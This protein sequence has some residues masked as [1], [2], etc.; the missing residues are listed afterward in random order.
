MDNSLLYRYDKKA[1]NFAVDWIEKFCSHA[2]G[3]LGGKPFKLEKWQKEE[4]IKPLFGWKRKSDGLRRYKRCA[5][6][7]PR[8]NGKSTLGSA[9]ALYMLCADGE[10][11]AEIYSAASDRTQAGI[12]HEVAKTMVN[13]N[14]EL[15][16]RVQ[17][18]QNSIVYEKTASF[19][20]AIS[21]DVKTKHG[22]NAHCIIFDELH[23]QPNRELWD[24]LT[25]SIGARTQPIVIIFTTA[26]YDKKSICYNQYEYAKKVK[27]GI[28]RD[29]TFLPVIYESA[30][31][32]DIN[33]EKVW[34]IANPNYGISLK[35]QYVR[36][37]A[38]RAQNEP[39]YENTFRRLQ[40]NQWTSSDV[41]WISDTAWMASDHG[42]NMASLEGKA[43]YAGL[44]LASKRDITSFVLLFPPDE[45]GNYNV[46]P[47]FFIPEMNHQERVKKDNVPYDQWIKQGFVIETPGDVT[48]YDFI[49]AKIMELNKKFNIKSIAFDRWNASQCVINLQKEGFEC[50]PFG[51]GFGSMSAPTKE[52][53]S[54]ILSKK[55]NHGGNPVLRWMASNV[56][57]QI[58]AADNKK[59]HKGKSTEKVDGMVALVMA[60]GE[61][62]TKGAPVK[63]VYEQS[64]IKKL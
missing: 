4:I 32:D 18:Y 39:G 45:N 25:T 27:A 35:E 15:R 42:V 64:G 21:S 57:L 49:Q 44:D 11:G 52:L 36:D 48:D 54:H 16:K 51:Q 5:V 46:L 14:S 2:K 23:A 41:R 20:K 7:V 59:I 10:K 61:Y 8:K 56:M 13:Q 3:E 22:F 24:V 6:F 47:F 63:S 17:V 60:L 9:I 1:A 33:D 19:Y 62:M 34:A 31:T 40:L 43:C 38:L 12:I 30:E 26:G 53:E 37:E 58:D 28:I 29:D 55:I 50:S